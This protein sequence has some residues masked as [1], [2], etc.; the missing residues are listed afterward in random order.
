MKHYSIYILLVLTLNSCNQQ[1]ASEQLAVL[2]GYWEIRKVELPDGTEKEFGVNT[3]IDFIE[4]TGDS[5]VRKKVSPRLDGTFLMTNSAE[6]FK[7]KIEGDCL[8]LY[9]QTPFDQWKETVLN[10][11]DSLLVMQNTDGKIY[12]YHRYKPFTLKNQ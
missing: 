3:N 11:K 9:Y 5:G 4:V 7:I 6:K 8:N 2:P 10:T 12:T 1:D